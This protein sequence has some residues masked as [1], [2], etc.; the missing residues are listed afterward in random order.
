VTTIEAIEGL[1]WADPEPGSTSLIRRCA[2]LRRKPLSEFTIEDMRIMLSQQI[3]VST[4]LPSAVD[5][6]LRDPL[7]EGDY[8]AGDL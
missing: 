7:A 1:R 2:A 5:V 8:Y 4:L 3:G 6:L